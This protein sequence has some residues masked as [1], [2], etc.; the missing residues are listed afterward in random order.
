M[1][2]DLQRGRWSASAK[3][4]KRDKRQLKKILMMKSVNSSLWLIIKKVR[5][6]GQK[7]NLLRTSRPSW[8]D[9][10]SDMKESDKSMLKMR[11]QADHSS[12]TL[13]KS[14]PKERKLYT[15][16]C[17]TK[18][19]WAFSRS[20]SS[21][22]SRSFWIKIDLIR[23][24]L[25]AACAKETQSWAFIKWMWSK[26]LSLMRKA[27]RLSVKQDKVAKRQSRSC[28][29]TETGHSQREL[30]HIVDNLYSMHYTILAVRW[31]V[32]ATQKLSNSKH[33]RL[34]GS[35]KPRSWIR[36]KRLLRWLPRSS[37]AGSM[38]ESRK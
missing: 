22:K 2:K 19:R 4:N 21:R 5:S 3:S 14:V 23:L 26:Q 31:S 13:S 37:C 12:W 9:K 16:D 7:S 34:R 32:S 1:R 10:N 35:K 36:T 20:Y 29:T 15:I 25:Q 38:I 24:A 17:I 8:I 11:F 33:W 18:P 6:V 28:L 30:P 27:M